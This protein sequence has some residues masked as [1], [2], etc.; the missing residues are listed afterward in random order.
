MLNK[1]YKKLKQQFEMDNE[2]N[3]QPLGKNELT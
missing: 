1:K 2:T 3:L